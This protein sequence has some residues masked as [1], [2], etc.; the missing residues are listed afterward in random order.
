MPDLADSVVMITGGSE[1]LGLALAEAFSTSGA[2]VSICSRNMERLEAAQLALESRGGRVLSV[3]AD[4]ADPV[5]VRAWYEHTRAHAGVPDVL[6]NNASVLG[7]REAI[8]R[9]PLDEWRSVIDV[10]LTGAFIASQIVLPDLLKRRSGSIINVSSGAAIPPRREWGA[11]AVSKAG[12]DAFSLNLAEELRSTGV[13]VNIVDPGAMRTKMRAA[14]YPAENPETLKG[15]EAIA[16][17]FL[18]LAS[19]ESRGVTGERFRA[20]EWLAARHGEM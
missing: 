7:P 8:E 5:S 13:R 14:A 3:V 17:L 19:A 11:Y 6:I 12:L 18:W 15:P 4:V 20:D 9:Y 1:G 16:P 2:S 10:N